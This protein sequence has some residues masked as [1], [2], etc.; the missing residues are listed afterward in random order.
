VR[1]YS[2]VEVGGLSGYGPERGRNFEQLFYGIC[3]RRGL[4][5]S[6][7]AGSRSLAGQGSASGFGHEVDG[8]TRAVRCV[9]HWE[10]KHLTSPLDK[11]ALLIFNGKTLDYLHGS[12]A[13]FVKIPY[14]RFLLSGTNVRDE[15]RY[16]AALWSIMLVEPGRLPLPLLYEAVSRGGADC[17]SEPDRDVIRDRVAW[18]CRPL[19][20]VV[21]SLSVW[22]DNPIQKTGYGPSAFRSAKEVTDAQEQIGGDVLDD[23]DEQ[24]PGW[25]DET[26]E[27]TWDEVG[28]W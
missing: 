26:A 22:L 11:N 28:G 9:T 12:Q 1:A 4:A 27:Q 8:A 10:L 3:E 2:V 23:L 21:R 19:Q 13:F 15:S 7:R 5:L 14:M 17:L 6:E 25:V 16:Y 18:A 20:S 24:F